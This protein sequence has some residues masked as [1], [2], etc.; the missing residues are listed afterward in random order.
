[1]EKE[2]LT[3]VVKCDDVG[4]LNKYVGCKIDYNK[5]EGSI[6]IMQLILIQSFEDEFNLPNLK[7]NTLAI[8][9][10]VLQPVEADFKEEPPIWETTKKV[11]EKCCI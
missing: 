9:G 3:S 6:K 11:W 1:M 8:L 7:P 10:S 5:M 2:K 4:E